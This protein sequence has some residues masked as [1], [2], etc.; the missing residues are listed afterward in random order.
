ML[1]APAR[2]VSCSFGRGGRTAM[3]RIG[4]GLLAFS[5][6]LLA[7]ASMQAGRVQAKGDPSGELAEKLGAYTC[8]VV[9]FIPAVILLLIGGRKRVEDTPPPRR[10]AR[11]GRESDD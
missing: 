11:P 9:V 7:M 1:A 8:P 3:R 2:R 10:R 4:W 5:A 6:V